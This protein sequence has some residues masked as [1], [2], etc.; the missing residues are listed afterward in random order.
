MGLRIGH[1][2]GHVLSFALADKLAEEAKAF[3]FEFAWMEAIAEHNIGNLALCINL[4]PALPASNG[5]H[6][7]AWQWVQRWR[8][9]G[10]SGK[11]MFRQL[12]R[13][14]LRVGDAA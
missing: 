12:S 5:L 7:V 8:T 10:M 4:S 11:E 9:A 14:Q 13:N 1:E 2:I 6:D 3:A